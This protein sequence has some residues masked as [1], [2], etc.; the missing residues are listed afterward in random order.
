MKL[1]EMMIA[2]VLVTV[3]F[4]G[5]MLFF[6]D[7]ATHYG[8]SDINAS[9][10]Q[11]FNSSMTK[12]NNNTQIVANALTTLQGSPSAIDIFGSILSGGYAAIQTATASFGAIKDVFITSIVILPLGSFKVVLVGAVTTILLIILFVAILAPYIGGRSNQL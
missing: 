4:A 8:L 2:G 12:I 10:M 6:I 7:G 9:Q 5:I 3:F 1:H 11:S